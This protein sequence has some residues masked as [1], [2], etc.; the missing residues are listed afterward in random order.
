M[1]I[2]LSISETVCNLTSRIWITLKNEGTETIN[3]V[4][5]SL[6]LDSLYEVS[7]Y[8]P[9]AEQ[10]GN[11]ISMEFCNLDFYLYIQVMS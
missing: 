5:L 10:N 6:W 1:S 7:D 4:N 8:S 2:D 9:F 3:N 11:N